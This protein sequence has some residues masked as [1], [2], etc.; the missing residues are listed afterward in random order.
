[1]YVS[2][3][4]IVTLRLYVRTLVVVKQQQPSSSKTT[5]TERVGVGE[6]PNSHYLLY[7]IHILFN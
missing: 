5:T 7:F 3:S 1:M 6:A 2:S 4:T